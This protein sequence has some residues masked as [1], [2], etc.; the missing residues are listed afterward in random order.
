[1][2]GRGIKSGQIGIRPIAI[3]AAIRTAANLLPTRIDV[4]APVRTSGN[5]FSTWRTAA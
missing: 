5:R 4:I 1:M 2:V 3:I